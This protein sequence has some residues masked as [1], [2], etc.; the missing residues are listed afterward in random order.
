MADLVSPSGFWQ[1]AIPACQRA[2]SYSLPSDR[3]PGVGHGPASPVGWTLRRFRFLF[4]TPTDPVEC[5][6]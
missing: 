3:P 1:G 4:G 6:A 5:P 2:S